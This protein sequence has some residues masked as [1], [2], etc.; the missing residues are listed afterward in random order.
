[1]NPIY[2]TKLKTVG[3]LTVV[4][5]V[6]SLITGCSTTAEGNK[7]NTISQTTVKQLSEPS[8]TY[9]SGAANQ[10]SPATWMTIAEDNYKAKRYARALRAANEALSMDNQM[11]E[12]RQIAMLSAV[13]VMESNIDAY[14]D[15]ALMN[16]SDKATFKETLTNITTSINTS[17]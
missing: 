5:N 6:A 12:A 3:L 14:H 2:R 4:L 8:L 9:L 15:N 16:D 17:N 11:V 7:P 1:M 13:K 10:R